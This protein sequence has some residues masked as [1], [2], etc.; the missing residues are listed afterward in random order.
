M[1]LTELA[2]KR[3]SAMSMIIMFFIVLGIFG[4]SKIGSDLFPKANMPIVTIVAQYPGAGPEEMEGQV[5]NQ[6]EEAVASLSGLKTSRSYIYEGVS[7][8]VLE[9]TMSTNADYAAM[10]AQKA[11]DKAM[12][13]LPPDIEKPLVQKID[14]NAEPIMV[15]AVTGEKPLSEIYETA[16]DTVK[17]RLETVPGV[18]GISVVGGQ[19]QQVR[20]EIDRT[21]MES[22][23]VAANQIIQLLKAE[24][25]N[26]PSGNINNNRIQYDVRLVGKFKTVKDIENLPVHLVT[27]TTVPLG[28]MA[29]VENTF[30]EVEQYS[31]M[32]KETAVSLVIQK[33]SDA[34][35]VDT[36]RNVR[37]ELADIQKGMPNGV[38][39]VVSDD[40]SIFINN[41]LAD[42]QRTLFEGIIMTGIVLL[43]FLREWRS[44]V[45][46][47]LAIPTSIVATFMMMYL[48][49][50]TFNM[51]SLMGL[52]LCVGILVDDSIVVLE[53]IHRHMQMGKNPVQAAIDGRQEIGMAA[54]AIT[55][56]DVV[57]FGPMAFM[58]GLVG[59]M[60]R[61][62]GMTVVVATLFSLFISFTLTPMLAARFYKNSQ[63]GGAGAA[64][65]N[66]YWEW[67]GQT[68]GR[69]GDAVLELYRKLLTWSLNHRLKMLAII[70][71]GVLAAGSLIN[72]IGF[73]FMSPTDQGKFKIEVEMPA[74]TALI[75]TDGFVRKLEERIDQIPEVDH[76]LVTVGTQAGNLFAV[77]SPD[78]A[79]LDVVLSTKNDRA[80][81]V[82]QVA[83][84]VRGWSDDYPG[85][86]LSITEAQMPGLNNF[87]APIILEVRGSDK[88]ILADYARKIE[89]IVR[90]A[91]GT[92]DVDMSWEENVKPEYQVVVDRD[93]AAG[94]G[95]TAADIAQALRGALAGDKASKIRL[96]NK[97][98][99]IWVQLSDVD[100]RSV[101]DIGNITVANRM[102]QTFLIKQMADI[103]PAKGP[104]E[105]RHKNRERMI[106][107][108]ANYKD[109]SLSALV[110]DFDTKIA[111]LNLPN[112]YSFGYD[113]MIK[114]M[115]ESNADLGTV[116]VL[117]LIL[118]YMIL[119]IL[120]ESF[121]TPFIRMLSL[122]VG[123]IGAMLALFLTHNTLN[124]MSIIGIIML[125][126]LAAK[127]GTLL[128][129]Y[130]N[131]LMQRGMNLR[132]ALIEAGTK[133]LRPIFMTSTTM[134]FGMLPT[135]LALA[136]GAE[137]RKGMGIVLVGGL[138]TS[139]I[140]TPI[141][142]P[143]AYTLIDDFKKWIL[144]KRTEAEKQITA[145]S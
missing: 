31:R 123:I 14:M 1:K 7:F 62:F 97:D 6:I 94:Y 119:V 83:D 25:I 54:V 72:A 121:L 38:K 17:A 106:S 112:G 52:S 70:L 57:V 32:D 84:I 136:D 124:I 45:I 44:V 80:K 10:D 39:L 21:K 95:F 111:G 100:R 96:D 71:G 26:V 47:M 81:T 16:N 3:P 23:G 131:T 145:A 66:K 113:G 114:Q 34:S 135:A 30:A 144:R 132:E 134:I 36:V 89:T 40:Q 46:V 107:I 109:V 88:D 59:Q 139:T 85:V 58:Q 76:V 41:S 117:S 130:T 90:E 104:T 27:G 101:E 51:L 87:E 33:Q 35:I 142:I 127:N 19:K 29:K 125:D 122:P 93:K 67:L 64:S 37:A 138:I 4:Y 50:Y 11:V 79:K 99:D 120:Y 15:L 53:N 28:E 2:I 20:V 91:P 86:K 126:G 141:L 105:I 60:F 82:W 56:S 69:L 63:P 129:D 24:N 61:Q 128:I 13:Q 18:A 137:L 140:L 65:K 116:L 12:M 55:L 110:Q 8:T 48:F 49:G 78:L 77:S 143:V 5:T 68:S 108:L 98:V 42:T 115:N 73:E 74:G 22:Y 102:G 43:F 9:F 75:V 118:V 133:R 103:S 92:A